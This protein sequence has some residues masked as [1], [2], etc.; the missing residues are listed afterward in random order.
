MAQLSD[1][2]RPSGQPRK[3]DFRRLSRRCLQTIARIANT[4]ASQPTSDISITPSDIEQLTYG[5]WLALSPIPC[6]CVFSVDHVPGLCAIHLDDA[7][8]SQSLKLLTDFAGAWGV[9]MHPQT[10]GPSAQRVRLAPDTDPIVV[11]PFDIRVGCHI[12]RLTFC[13]PR[14][15]IQ[16]LTDLRAEPS[17]AERVIHRQWLQANVLAATVEL[18]AVL[19]QTTLQRA[20][21]TQLRPG[22]IITTDQPISA[23][24]SLAAAGKPLFPARPVTFRGQR[25]LHITD[26][27]SDSL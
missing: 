9:P 23:G 14:P 10:C 8:E 7:L 11:I 2:D 12:G 26:A 5:D 19:A 21:L 22:D 27:Q 6:V 20:E 16:F 13:C 1:C 3:H 18:R 25:A 17:A 24:A 4:F 15:M